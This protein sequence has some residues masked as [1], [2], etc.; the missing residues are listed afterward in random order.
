LQIVASAILADVESGFPP[1]GAGVALKSALKN[2]AAATFP[3]ALKPLR[4]SSVFGSA[5]RGCK[6]MKHFRSI[7]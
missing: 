7:T 6:M 3:A 4:R 1:G 5:R 2:W